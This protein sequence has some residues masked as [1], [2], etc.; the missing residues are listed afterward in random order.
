MT[1]IQPANV[2]DSN[3]ENR[4]SLEPVPDEVKEEIENLLEEFEEEALSDL[5]VE[6]RRLIAERAGQLVMRVTSVEQFSG[7]LP[8][9]RIM[10]GYENIH[11][12][13]ADRILRMAEREQA[14]RHRL[15]RK[16]LDL[17][18]EAMRGAISLDRRGM[19]SALSAVL[20]TVI[21]GIILTAINANVGV[22]VI[23][24]GNATTLAGAF[25]YAQRM[26]NSQNKAAQSEE[27][28][29][30]NESEPPKS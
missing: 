3:P 17:H 15:E 26:K 12:G 2:E 24:L 29:V 27:R 8:H 13:S 4:S 18:A 20:V 6:Q 28:R 5:P 9:P 16:E 10:R 11:A 21:G 30:Q 22:F 19:M 1:D 7:N 23:I 14:H 25:Y